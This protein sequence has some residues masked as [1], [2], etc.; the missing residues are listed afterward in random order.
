M[1][2]MEDFE[3]VGRL[4]RRGPPALVGAQ[5]SSCGRG[6]SSCGR[7]QTLYISSALSFGGIPWFRCTGWNTRLWLA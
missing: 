2:F 5:G 4:R 3:L 6:H 7:G 1:T